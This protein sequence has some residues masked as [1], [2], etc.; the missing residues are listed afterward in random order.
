MHIYNY[1][2]Y[3]EYY[4]YKYYYYI[5]FVI[6]VPYKLTKKKLNQMSYLLNYNFEF[7]VN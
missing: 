3:Y 1:Y 5:P 4:E 7:F 2:Y 6:T